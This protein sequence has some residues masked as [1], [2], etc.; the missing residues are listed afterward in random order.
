MTTLTASIETTSK[1]ATESADL[2]GLFPAGTH[3]YVTDIGDTIETQVAAAARLRKLGY[4]PVVHIAARRAT[5][6]AALD[7]R[8]RRLVGEADVRDVLVVGGGLEKP[9]GDFTGTMDILATGLIDGHGIKR[10]GVAGHPEGSPDFSEEV[11]QK[12]L[13]EKRAWAERTGAEMRIV[14]QFGFNP[15]KFIAW[16]EGLKAHGIDLPVHLGVAGPAKITT[17]L[18]YAVMCGVGESI[19]FLK[20]NALSVVALAGSQSPE[21]IVGPIEAHVAATPGSAIAR[22]HVFPF[23]G[24]KGSATW[25]VER[26]SWDIKKSLYPSAAAAG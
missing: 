18:K 5:T 16:A 8:L 22:I 2:P 6:R 10:L 13:V 25:L 24:L 17:L 11:A 3:V 12:I 19:S 1:Q 21:P 26:G 15:E 23:G 4:E 9:A 20:R 7:E 14:T